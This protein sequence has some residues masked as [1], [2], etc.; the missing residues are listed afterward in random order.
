[1]CQKFKFLSHVFRSFTRE[2]VKL[3]YCLSGT[4]TG[5]LTST[6]K[7]FLESAVLYRT[8]TFRG[9]MRAGPS[10]DA[11]LLF[12]STR[13]TAA[14]RQKILLVRYFKRASMYAFFLNESAVESLHFVIPSRKNS[15][16]VGKLSKT[17]Q[18]SR[19]PKK[20]YL[21]ERFQKQLRFFFLFWFSTKSGFF[22]ASAYFLSNKHLMADNRKQQVT[23]GELFFG[24]S[25]ATWLFP[26]A[27]QQLSSF[28]L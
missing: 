15:S 17:V 13:R 2:P 5:V 27:S 18:L 23:L 6:I 8:V 20:A 19:L 26:G 22:Y 25:R 4:M 14:K 1:M 28:S 10:E 11:S 24:T 3:S 9:G 7:V 21:S 16:V 12:R